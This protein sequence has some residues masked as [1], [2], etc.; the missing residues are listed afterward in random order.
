[1]EE[2]ETAAKIAYDRMKALATISQLR[3]QHRD[4]MS[5]AD[6]AVAL[7]KLHTLLNKQGFEPVYHQN[8]QILIYLPFNLRTIERFQL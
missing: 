1:M 3:I 7:I 8:T 5:A 4:P 2:G 6:A